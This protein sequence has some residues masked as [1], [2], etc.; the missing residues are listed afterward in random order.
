MAKQRGCPG[1]RAR[2][3]RIAALER[4]VA[5]LEALVRDLTARLGTNAS[6]SSLPPSANPPDAPKPVVKE[7]TGR[8]TGG[9]PGHPPHPRRRL[10][11]EQLDH[12]IPLVP[13]RCDRCGAGL[14]AQSG[15]RDPEPTWHPFAELPP[16]AAVVTEFQGPARTC[17]CGGHLTRAAIPAAIGAP[18]LGPRLTAALG[19]LAGSV[20]VSQRGLGEIAQTLFGVPRAVG[21]VAN[22]QQ[23]VS[24]ALEPAHAAARQAVRAAPVKHADETSWKLAGG[25][26]WLWVAATTA[27]AYFVVVPGRGAD[28]LRQLLGTKRRGLLCSDRWSAYGAWAVRRRQVCW[29]HRKR[30]FRKLAERGGRAAGYGEKG[31]AVV[32]I[33]FHWWHAYR[34][35][36]CSRAELRS[37]LE[38]VRQ[39]MRDWL[40][41]GTRCRDKK[42][43]RFCANLLAWEPALWTF[44][45]EEGVAPTN[46]HAERVLRRAVLW[47]KRSF[48]SASEAGCTFVGRL[49]TVVQAQRLQ[50]RPVLEYLAE[51]VTAYRHGLPAPKLLP[52]G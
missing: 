7:P 5:E 23:E 43:A 38:P 17:P 14:P 52:E 1:C 20:P 39:V 16:T 50:Q 6:N 4:R 37:E 10:P 46:N 2:D 19:Y 51:A 29:A 48:G 36:G 35:G 40:G 24:A 8:A 34:G 12:G 15:P 22:R 33:L 18:T 21:R 32:G 13:D 25:L 42:V 11:P 28:G 27:V 47:R 49:L 26:R 9:P 3:A 30:D 41:G 31:L 45:D 44:V